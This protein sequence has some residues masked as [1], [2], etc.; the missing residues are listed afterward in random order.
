MSF[1]S[2]PYKRR[3]NRKQIDSQQYKR[4]RTGSRRAIYRTFDEDD[5]CRNETSGPE[6]PREMVEL[7]DDWNFGTGN[8]SPD[9]WEDID[10]ETRPLAPM[11][12]KVS[13]RRRQALAN[14]WRAIH[15]SLVEAFLSQRKC[16]CD[17]SS[18]AFTTRRKVLHV[19]LESAEWRDIASCACKDSAASYLVEGIFPAAPIRPKIVFH[20][21]VLELFRSVLMEGPVSK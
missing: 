4:Y 16:S 12:S 17:T 7:P 3:W 13:G 14:N 5:Q 15:S 10:D 20:F 19:S 21:N 2:D 6:R 11:A 18:D 8:G 1:S 9:E